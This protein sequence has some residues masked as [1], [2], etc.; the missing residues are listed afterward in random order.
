MQQLCLFPDARPAPDGVVYYGTDGSRIKIGH[1]LRP[2]RRRGGELGI[3]M[4]LEEPGGPWV[5]RQHHRR[6]RAYR[7][8]D[9]EWFYPADGLL[10][11]LVIELTGRGSTG[12]LRVVEGLIRARRVE[13]ELG[14]L[15]SA[16][17]A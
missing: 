6:W 14:V 12:R 8:G 4:L 9:T 13:G 10:L 3:A 15:H 1:T 7:I 5:E 11:W 17:A 16:G 2:V